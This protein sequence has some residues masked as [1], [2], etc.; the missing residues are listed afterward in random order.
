MSRG[1]RISSIKIEAFRGIS[2]AL[3]FDL[4]SPITLIYAPNGTGKTTI[5]EAAEWLL[6]GQV[7]RLNT[8]RFFDST[9]LRSK[10]VMQNLEPLVTGQLYFDSKVHILQ[11]TIEALRTSEPPEQVARL[12]TESEKAETIERNEL[13][14]KLAPNAAADGAHATSAINLRQRWLRGTRFLSAEALAA[15]VDSDSETLEKRAQVFADLLGIRH[16]L[17]AEKVCGKFIS[18]LSSRKRGLDQ[19]IASQEEEIAKLKSSITEAESEGGQSGLTSAFTEI[20][21][22]EILLGITDDPVSIDNTQLKLRLERLTVELEKKSVEF[23]RRSAAVDDVSLRWNEHLELDEKWRSLSEQESSLA[24]KLG[25]IEL[26]GQGKT[27]SV[28]NSEEKQK[29][30]YDLSLGLSTAEDKLTSLLIE[31]IRLISSAEELNFPQDVTIADL[32]SILPEASWTKDAQSL[33]FN[34]LQKALAALSTSNDKARRYEL[35]I[36]QLADLR[37][38][39]PSEDRIAELRLHA[40]EMV[41]EA[42]RAREALSA[43]SDPIERLQAA[44]REFLIHTHDTELSSCP[45]C[46]HEWQSSGAMRFALEST[47]SAAPLLAKVAQDVFIVA[48]ERAKA[49]TLALNNAFSV[50]QQVSQLE[51]SAQELYASIDAYNK[52]LESLGIDINNTEH[53]L[54][55]A[56]KKIGIAISLSDLIRERD[57]LSYEI[58][59]QDTPL[60]PDNMPISSIYAY[61]QSLMSRRNQEIQLQLAKARS[62]LEKITAERDNL[63]VEHRSAS[64]ILRECRKELGNIKA[65]LE[66]LRNTWGEAFSDKEWSIHALVEIK[67]QLDTQKSTLNDVSVKL[68][69]VRTVMNV[70]L[71][72]QMLNEVFV[73]VEP[74]IIKRDYMQ[75]RIDAAKRA[76]AVFHQ[77]YTE[78]SRRQIDELT[79]VVNPLFARMHANRVYDHINLGEDN[80]FLHWLADAGTEQLD[81]GTDFS[82]G[83]RQDLALSLF[84]ARARTLG[85]TFFLDEPVA[86]LDDLNR[87]GLLDIFRATVVEGS[88][89]M[90]L[91]IT[92]SSKALARHFVEKFSS[93]GLVETPYGKVSPLRVIELDGNGRAGIEL[94]NVYPAR[95]PIFDTALT[96]GIEIN[97]HLQTMQPMDRF[98]ININEAYEVKYWSEMFGVSE[99]ELKAAITTVG[100]K[101]SNLQKLFRK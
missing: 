35:L 93:V 59:A 54:N 67:D 23:D 61:F 33:H 62:E 83:Q 41:E 46:S 43:V 60:L 40:N 70:E 64:G 18:E 42:S 5:C 22:S 45:L 2:N 11:R 39:L 55:S 13:L 31:V 68:S 95:S 29:V 6:T 32:K 74:T 94:K 30:I 84:L 26:N 8:E 78:V 7:E 92:T 51:L 75:K 80:N 85:G 49:A 56:V 57:L 28:I 47:L 82:Q 65:E 38:R 14:A 58:I 96:E 81:P 87:V 89:S 71:R 79:R 98:S 24:I 69:A 91:V 9:V 72:Q 52:H 76:K 97:A 66:V 86:H 3:D 90:N 101:I 34:T 36:K 12:S 27:I 88:N 44:G 17:D 15:L 19:M 100:A 4:T 10:F 1:V 48:D 20:Q 63:R 16:L 37:E 77:T 53:E 25:E 50:S 99:V 73:E 21:K